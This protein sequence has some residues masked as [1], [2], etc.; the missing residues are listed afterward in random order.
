M[1]G[2]VS[3]AIAK[4]AG[5]K[6]IE[7]CKRIGRLE[8]VCES[9]APPELDCKY[10]IHVRAPTN[11][12]D[13]RKIFMKAILKAEHLELKDISFP[14]IGTGGQDLKCNEVAQALSEV[15]TV[16]AH[17]KRFKYIKKVRFVAFDDKK[18]NIFLSEIKKQI[19]MASATENKNKNSSTN[20]IIDGLP[21]HWEPMGF[22]VLSLPVELKSDTL[23]FDDINKIFEMEK[24]K[25]RDFPE[26]LTLDRVYRLQ[27]P[28]LYN[29]YMAERETLFK[30]YPNTPSEEITTMEKTVFHGTS[31]DSVK[32]I[33]SEG[34]HKRF[35]GMHGA[36][37]GKGVY[38]A[39][40][41]Y[42]S[43]LHYSPPNSRQIK[44]VYIVKAL[45]GK[46]TAGN[47]TMQSLPINSNGLR[48]D[49]AVDNP[50]NPEIF[51][52]FEESHVY[53]EYIL[54]IKESKE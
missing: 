12:K 33:N 43:C 42:L 48:F 35:S 14:L 18:F 54:H 26:N 21:Q 1:N 52:I 47:E 38:F 8:D 39:R 20:P 16:A 25:R 40:D 2:E 50:Q 36:L 49:S 23:E 10:V 46:Y 37:Y 9:K 31:E 4:R 5:A 19:E 11:S 22:V 27:N 6:W 29:K 17:Q 24:A 44:F 45:V 51:V 28:I 41:L 30:K 34:F 15:V 7:Q 32:K 13:C 3:L 53:P